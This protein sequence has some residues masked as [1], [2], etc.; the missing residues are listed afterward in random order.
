MYTR[1]RNAWVI[2]IL[3]ISLIILISSSSFAPFA[4]ATLSNERF[5][6][7]HYTARFPSGQ[8]I[9]GDH[10]CAAGEYDRTHQVFAYSQSKNLTGVSVLPIIPSPPEKENVTSVNNMSLGSNTGTA[11]NIL[12]EKGTNSLKLSN[13]NLP[14]V[15]PL[16]KGL[17]NGQDIFYII[18]EASDQHIASTITKFTNFPVTFAP[19][20]AKTPIKS[21]AQ[22]YVFTNGV[23]GTGI[24]GYQPN[25]VDSIPSQSGYSPL[26]QINFVQWKIPSN[27]T[28]LSSYEQIENAVMD[29]IVLVS[30]TDII[31]NGPLIQWGVDHMKIRDNKILT[32]TT[33]YGGAQI[34][35]INTN[36]MKVTF[37]AHR[38]FA[39][40]GSTIYYITTDT[41]NKDQSDLL[42]LTF[43]NK[44]QS[45]LTTSSSSDLYQFS[46]GLVGTGPIGFQSGIGT[47]KPTDQFYSP[48]WRI[49]IITWKDPSV[50]TVLENTHDVVSKSDEITATLAGFVINCPFFSA[51]TVFARMK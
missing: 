6:F 4:N 17:F 35:D 40:D 31:L 8:K 27:A 16:V 20:L 24:L 48:M 5:D 49:Q 51:D 13:T 34:L 46:N 3:S 38:G 11:N 7:N 50:A 1:Q 12:T 15:I 41:S 43:T 21:L 30:Q 44:T 37:V 26:W 14:L 28:V 25:V 39:P 23:N 18:T 10:I 47:T 33:P 9:C 45:T 36:K 29:G 22:I 2:P 42:G 32:E 19:V